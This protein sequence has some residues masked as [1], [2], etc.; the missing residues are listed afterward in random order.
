MKTR[1]Y[2]LA[3]PLSQIFR[4]REGNYK[5][6]RRNME[7]MNLTAQGEGTIMGGLNGPCIVWDCPAVKRWVVEF[8]FCLRKTDRV[9]HGF[10]T[11]RRLGIRSGHLDGYI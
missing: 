1:L 11:R 9:L 5:L 3:Y 6:L 8:E 2:E 4:I 7:A 10:Q